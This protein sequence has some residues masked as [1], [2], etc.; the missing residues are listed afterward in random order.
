MEVVIRRA[1]GPDIARLADVERD[2]DRRFDGYDGVPAG[3]VDTASPAQLDTACD[4]GRLW[5]AVGGSA[6]A[7][8]SPHDGRIIGFALAEIVDGAVHLAQVSVRLDHQGRG[9]GGR[10][11]DVVGA[12]AEHQGIGAVTLC[13]FDDVSWNRPFYEHRGFVVVPEEQWTSGLRAVFDSDGHLGLDLSRR[14]VMRL[15]LP[16]GS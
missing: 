11:V 6:G 5:V 13:T 9:V 16:L 7:D 1:R 15:D 2:G 12:Y 3:F 14:V 8:P 10:L 4:A